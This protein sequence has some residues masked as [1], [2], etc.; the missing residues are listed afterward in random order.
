MKRILAL[1]AVMVTVLMLCAPAM[2]VSEASKITSHTT[3]SSDG[4]CQ[5][6][7]TGTFR[8]D[9]GEEKLYFPVPLEASS[10]MVNG[11]RARAKK[12]DSIQKVDITN[13][14]GGA[15]TIQYNL[16][17]AVAYNEEG[18]LVLTVPLLSGFA[19]PT[20]EMEFTVNL[21]GKTD[22]L[23]AFSSGYYHASIEEDIVYSV[24]ESSITGKIQKPLKDHETLEMTLNVDSAMFPQVRPEKQSFAVQIWGMAICGILA[25]AYW[26]LFLRCPPPRRMGATTPPEGCTAGELSCMLNLQGA[27]LSLMVYTW[28]QLGYVTIQ[29]DRR[30]RVLLHKRM[31][32][33]NERGEFEQRCFKKLFGLRKMTDT[34]GRRYAELAQIVGRKPVGVRELVKP[35]FGNPKVFRGLAAGAAMFGGFYLG[36]VLSQGAVLQWIT[37]ILLS[38][39]AAVSAWYIQQLGSRLFLRWQEKLVLGLLL[40]VAWLVLSAVAGLFYVGLVITVAQLLCGLMAAFGGRRTNLG[41]RTMAQILG[42]RRYLCR[43][44]KPQLE[45]VT[46]MDPEYFFSMM[47]YAMALGVEQAFARNFGKAKLS[48]CPYLQTGASVNMTAAEWCDTMIRVL[49]S[50]DAGTG[51]LSKEKLVRF[52]RSLTGQ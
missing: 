40:C 50:M 13:K 34:A 28:A 44:P 5:V 25:L 3:V 41:R 22:N 47:P 43:I 18:L 42:L 49:R 10:V 9:P 51:R 36:F 48:S 46:A 24:S 15:V 12:S 26:L 8:L 2:A 4:T 7:L 17:N 16:P 35:G 33:G 27:Q 38:V 23:P 14:L 39:L 6:T 19:Y 1:M 45:R 32:M 52:V 29:V 11:K 20:Q 21:P 30:D 37:A 31:D